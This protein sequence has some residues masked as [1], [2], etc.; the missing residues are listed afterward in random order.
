MIPFI[1]VVKISSLWATSVDPNQEGH[2]PVGFS[3]SQV[4]PHQAEHNPDGFAFSQVDPNQEEHNPDGCS[5]SQVVPNQ[6]EH[7]P[8]GFSFSQDWL[9]EHEIFS[10]AVEEF[11]TIPISANQQNLTL[12]E[13]AMQVFNALLEW[14]EF[15]LLLVV[16][17]YLHTWRL[18]SYY[19]EQ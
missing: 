13:W 10:D 3:F 7:N 4:D 8:D 1:L 14:D 12:R 18:Y 17:I 9:Q 16:L 19:T 5:F 6:E 2:N 11:E 15:G